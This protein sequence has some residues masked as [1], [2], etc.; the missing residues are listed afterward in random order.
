MSERSVPSDYRPIG[1]VD[2]ER[3]E[4]SVLRRLPLRLDYLEAGERRQER[5]IALDV[6]TRE[7]AEWLKFRRTDGEIRELRLDR[8]VAFSEA[9]SSPE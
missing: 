7:G 6:Y 3:L 8:I 1:C 5:V 4:F 9:S 2:H